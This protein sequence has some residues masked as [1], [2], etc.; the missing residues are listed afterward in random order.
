M[1]SVLKTFKG[2]KGE[3]GSLR[4]ICERM[5]EWKEMVREGLEVVLRV[6]ERER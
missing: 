3:L 6:V 4:E 1:N 5:E 2:L